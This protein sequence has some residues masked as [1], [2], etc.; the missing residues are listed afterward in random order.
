[1][2]KNQSKMDLKTVNISMAVATSSPGIIAMVLGSY[3]II[4]TV[5]SKD[6]FE[7]YPRTVVENNNS[8]INKPQSLFEEE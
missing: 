7:P 1:M 5:E 2:E 4:S 6:H 8:E 3:L